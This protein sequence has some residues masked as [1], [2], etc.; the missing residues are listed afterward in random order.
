[1]ALGKRSRAWL[2]PAYVACLLAAGIC[3]APITVPI[4]A[5]DSFIRYKSGV[6]KVVNHARAVK[7]RLLEISRAAK[8]LTPANKRRMKK[9]YKKLLALTRRVVRE[10]GKAI[11]RWPKL[12]N[13]VLQQ[14]LA[15]FCRKTR[16]LLIKR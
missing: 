11:R 10:S 15:S 2:K 4:L 1:S 12:K 5:P 9:S 14:P 3:L 8:S 7:H 6:L 13:G 16:K